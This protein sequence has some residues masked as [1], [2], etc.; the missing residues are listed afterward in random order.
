MK[1]NKF[2]K[3]LDCT[4]RDG[5]YYNN[6]FFK[7][8]LVQN[9]L[10]SC[11]NSKID[12][13]ELGF[14]FLNP[15]KGLGPYAFT[16]EACLN[17]ITI[18]KNL[19]ISVMINAAEFYGESDH[20]K[21][22]LT[23]IFI[24]KKLSKVS[25]VRIAINFNSFEKGFFI[26]KFLKQYGYEVG[27]NL[28]QSHKKNNN[29]IQNTVKK[30]ISW[31]TVDYLYY[32]DSMGVMDPEYISFISKNFIKFSKKTNIGIHA[33]NN[34]SLALINS[35][36]AI[37][38]N[39]NIIDSTILGMGR[40]AGNTPTEALLLELESLG[41]KYKSS[42]LLDILEYFVNLQ[43]K[44]QWGP[45][46]YYHYAAINNIHPT[47][48]QNLLDDKRYNLDQR[49]FALKSLK[50]K[51]SNIF[52]ED[53]LKSAIYKKN[54]FKD[55][56]NASNFFKNKHICI[57]ASGP[58]GNKLSKQVINYIKRKKPIVLSLNINQYIPKKYIDYYVSSYEYR[59]FFDAQFFNKMNKKIIMPYS[60]FKK[61]LNNR[62]N[63]DFLIDYGLRIKNK[64]FNVF[65]SYCELDS[66]L[67]IAYSL[68]FCSIGSAKS[69]NLAFVDGYEGDD[70]KNLAISNCI[71]KFKNKNQ[72]IKLKFLTPSFIKN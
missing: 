49:K 52:S 32:A 21:K 6:W 25:L 31:G 29:D 11:H 22:L 50:A 7:K 64:A 36:T 13:V 62:I 45:N 12:I 10:L 61:H 30:I 23:K 69:I 57:L 24:K 33:H 20:T 51:N 53:N 63:N 19:K 16:T 58:S 3:I 56:F 41:Y 40:G 59:V 72:K 27:F 4:L 55:N 48:I 44:Y 67:A 18:P 39:L 43:Q 35:I 42:Y 46:Y 8:D 28:M 34:K 66:P 65:D 47:Y 26:T 9:Y 38:N 54:E 5:G 60:L 37:N 68:A 14:R 2:L 17:Q 70:L 15:K 71:S 1:V